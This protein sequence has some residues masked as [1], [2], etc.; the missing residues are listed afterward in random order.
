MAVPQFILVPY[1]ADKNYMGI[2]N[3]TPVGGCANFGRFGSWT[4]NCKASY[5]LLLSYSNSF[6]NWCPVIV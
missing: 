1:Y 3:V 2:T 5:D 4:F 6:L